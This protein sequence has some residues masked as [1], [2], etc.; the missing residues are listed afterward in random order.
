MQLSE[1]GRVCFFAFERPNF[2]KLGYTMKTNKI[3]GEMGMGL[4]LNFV[5]KGY[6]WAELCYFK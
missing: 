2:K 4:D 5:G 6:L 3:S 1:Y